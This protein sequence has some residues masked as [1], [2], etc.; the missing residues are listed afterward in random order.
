MA[1]LVIM[2]EHHAEEDQKVMPHMEQDPGVIGAESQMKCNSYTMR[3]LDI[4]YFI[5]HPDDLTLRPL[6]AYAILA[7]RS[8]ECIARD[9]QANREGSLRN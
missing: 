9:D 4:Q 8:Y 6:H 2:S 3:V 5:V 7:R 1:K